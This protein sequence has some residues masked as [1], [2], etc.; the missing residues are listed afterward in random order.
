MTV[1]RAETLGIGGIVDLMMNELYFQGKNHV[2]LKLNATDREIL[3]I[4]ENPMGMDVLEGN[5]HRARCSAF[6]RIQNE[7]RRRRHRGRCQA[8]TLLCFELAKV[9]TIGT[10]NGP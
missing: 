9:R 8:H 10:G 5:Y 2:L 6:R 1:G 7:M 3:V 4:R